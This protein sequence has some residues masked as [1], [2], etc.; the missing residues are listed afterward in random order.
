[1]FVIWNLL[2][3]NHLES[4]SCNLKEYLEAI[5]IAVGKAELKFLVS[6]EVIS[7]ALLGALSFSR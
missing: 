3:K 5:K 6:L 1:M 2:D 7:K 4:Q